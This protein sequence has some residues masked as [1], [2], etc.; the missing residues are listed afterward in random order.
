MTA[1]PF[2]QPSIAGQPRELGQPVGRGAGEGG[3]GGEVRGCHQYEGRVDQVAVGGARGQQAGIGGAEHGEAVGVAVDRAEFWPC[4]Q[5]PGPDQDLDRVLEGVEERRPAVHNCPLLGLALD[6][7]GQR[8]ALEDR[9]QAAVGQPE[10][11]TLNRTDGQHVLGR[12]H[13]SHGLLR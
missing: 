7:E 4:L 1:S 8:W 9:P 5:R 3:L 11:V 13:C 12:A 6:A 10:R 2:P